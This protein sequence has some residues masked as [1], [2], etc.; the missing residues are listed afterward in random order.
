[1]VKRD[2]VIK[3]LKRVTDP[4]L[5][6]DIWSLGLVYDI[7]IEEETVKIRMTFTSPMCPLGPFI[8]E[9]V[10]TEVSAVRGVKDV[11]VDITFDP[12]WTPDRMSE[13]IRATLG[14]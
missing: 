11:E 7:S 13:E 9:G 12:L 2:D 3:A 10:K 1:M 6:V 14:L 4:E 8:I 5:G